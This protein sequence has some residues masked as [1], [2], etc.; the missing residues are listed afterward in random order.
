MA[1]LSD[2]D[3]SNIVAFFSVI[4][5]DSISVVL[6]TLDGVHF[7]DGIDGDFVVTCD[8]EETQNDLVD[9]FIEKPQEINVY[10]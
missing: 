1:T 8:G 3:R 4:I 2:H 9:I 7:P 6:G 5:A 10:G